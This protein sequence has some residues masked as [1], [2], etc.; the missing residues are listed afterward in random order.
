MKKNYIAPSMEITNVALKQMIADS[1]G[2]YS[3]TGIKYVGVD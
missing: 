1:N 3:D 2:V